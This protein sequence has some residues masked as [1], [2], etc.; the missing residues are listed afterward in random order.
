MTVTVLVLSFNRPR[1]LR[2]L[3]DSISA[4]TL[5]DWECIV[6][7]DGST[8]YGTL[9]AL[10][11]V[12]EGLRDQRFRTLRGPRFSPAEK[13]EFCSPAALYNAGMAFARGEFVSCVGVSITYRPQR[14]ERMVAHLRAAPEASAVWGHVEKVQLDGSGREIGRET[15]RESEQVEVHQGAAFAE[16]IA[17]GNYIDGP[18]ALERADAA[19][20]VPFS[21][22]PAGWARM[23]WDRWIA[24]ARAGRRFDM[25][26]RIGETKRTGPWNLGRMLAGGASLE[27][28][29]E[30]SNDGEA[31]A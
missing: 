18:S 15:P 25:I 17:R 7:D 14:L 30:R 3:L 6:C 22:S 13:R 16:R 12:D 20:L 19:R 31:V 29:I 4:Q 24:H 26:A 1:Q 21:T 23:D 11:E 5:E 9:Q 28:A 2:Q 8:D 10:G 27:E